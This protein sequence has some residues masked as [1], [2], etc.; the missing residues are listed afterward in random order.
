MAPF[1]SPMHSGPPIASSS[2]PA[3]HA[4]FTLHRVMAENQNWIGI[5]AAEALASFGESRLVYERFQREAEHA[6]TQP[7]RVGIWRVLASAAP[8]VKDRSQWI[9]V[10]E[11]T[12][13]DTNA[14]DR[15][16]AI[17]SLA[18]LG[19]ATTGPVLASVRLMASTPPAMNTVLPIWSLHHSGDA[20]ALAR[21][22]EL[23]RSE[24]PITRQRSAYALRWIKPPGDTVRAALDQATGAEPSG[25]PRLFML[26]AAL[27]L[28]ANPAQ[29][30]AWQDELEALFYRGSSARYEAG[31]ALAPL[32]RAS[33]L[34]RLEALLEDA[35]HDTRVAAAVMILHLSVRTAGPVK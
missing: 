32:C 16:Q 18:K 8:S 3:K 1:S 24:D 14:P 30:S 6:A 17:E 11:K 7:H 35:D 12:F 25:T 5:H 29:R 31:L 34:A 15:K 13:L 9:A 19:H 27:T 26:S 22:I 21:L 4:I 28:D 23:L 33:D 2:P 10:I 20:T